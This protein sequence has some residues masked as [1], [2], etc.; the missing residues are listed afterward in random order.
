M[1]L[2]KVSQSELVEELAD[3]LG[4][5]KGDVRNFFA[6]LTESV[7]SY[8]AEG[9]R[10]QFAGVLVEPKLR[11][12]SKARMGRNPATGEDV[13]IPAKPASVKLKVRAVAPLSKSEL[14][15]PKKLQKL[16]A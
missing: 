2:P 1:A 15:S 16:A 10:V 13:Q 5:S 11:K 9:N 3:S 12:A 6:A 14:P 4:W 8:I 7:Q